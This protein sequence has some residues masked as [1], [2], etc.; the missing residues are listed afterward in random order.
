MAIKAETV[1]AYANVVTALGTTIVAGS[2]TALG[3]IG[4]KLYKTVSPVVSAFLP[5]AE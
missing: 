4:Y 3:V 2:L 1:S 5:K